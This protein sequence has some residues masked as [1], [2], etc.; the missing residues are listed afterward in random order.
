MSQSPYL[1]VKMEA[2]MSENRQIDEQRIISVFT[3]LEWAEAF[4]VDRKARGLSPNTIDFYRKKLKKFIDFCNLNK[5]CDIQE[6]NATHVRKYVLWLE[7]KGHNKGEVHAHFREL[8]SLLYWYELENELTDWTNPI[9]KVKVNPPRQDPLDPADVNAVKAMLKVCDNDFTGIRDRLILLILL[10]TGLRA[11]ELLTLNFDNVNP[12]TGTLQIMHG[13]GDKFRVVYLGKK[14]RIAMRS[15]YRRIKHH[16]G[17]L[18]IGVHGE[19]LTYTGLRLILK[20]RAEKA[21]GEYQS[22]HSFRRLFALTML[23][24]G[25]DVF[26]LQLLMGHADLQMLRRYLKQ[27]GSDLQEAHNQ[28]SPVDK[29]KL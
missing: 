18:I 8:R 19:R 20:R 11:S 4:I 28:A 24:N 14:S 3:I 15:Y 6:L 17:A 22:P 26:S 1:A 10:D 12:I 25:I 13:K 5:I 27:A 9:K 2:E 29:W 23:R 7:K 16:E 21:G